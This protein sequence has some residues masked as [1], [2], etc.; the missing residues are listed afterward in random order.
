MPIIL[1]VLPDPTDIVLQGEQLR[2][3]VN[4]RYPKIQSNFPMLPANTPQ[5]NFDSLISDEDSF[6]PMNSFVEINRLSIRR[7]ANGEL[8]IRNNA[9]ISTPC[10]AWIWLD[11]SPLIN[12]YLHYV[13]VLHQ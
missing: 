8:Q 2:I 5:V 3:S 9:G 6:P 4:N 13:H 7:M 11:F 12:P 10:G 1:D